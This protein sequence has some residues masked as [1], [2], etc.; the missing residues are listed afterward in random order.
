MTP[1]EVV[2]FVDHYARWTIHMLEEMPTRADLVFWMGE[3]RQV[4][5]ITAKILENE[6]LKELGESER[7][8]LNDAKSVALNILNKMFIAKNINFPYEKYGSIEE[9][10][11]TLENVQIILVDTE[12]KL[13]P[14]DD[15]MYLRVSDIIRLSAPELVQLLTTEALRLHLARINL[16]DNDNL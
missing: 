6:S 9:L 2:L 12:E 14:K 7:N 16:L 5:D 13:L 1:E 3:R 11:K 10:N 8:K 4:V 15:A